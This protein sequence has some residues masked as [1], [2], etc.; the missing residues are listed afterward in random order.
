V[1]PN[2]YATQSWANTETGDGRRVQVAWMRGSSFP[3]MP[4][5]QEISFPCEL[6]LRSTPQGLR[7]FRQPIAEIASLHQAP[8]VWKDRTVKSGE[9][10]PLEPAGQL[11]HVQAEVSI[12]DGARLI[13]KLCGV[14]VVLTAKTVESGNAPAA[15]ADRITKVEILLDRASVE[16]YVNEG[17]ISSTRYVLPGENGL[18]VKA[19]GGAVTLKSLT[20]FPLNS[21]WPEPLGH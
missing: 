8:D 20:I 15:V 11:F 13:F 10:L 12:P 17:E 5:N 4:F 9:T 2:F 3:N 16:T 19:E 18:S 1:G 14:P 6:K 7:I 21:S